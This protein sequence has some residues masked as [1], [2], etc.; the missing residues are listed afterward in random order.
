MYLD[1]IK[2]A[3]VRAEQQ[4]HHT[5]PD[6]SRFDAYPHK[7]LAANEFSD[8]AYIVHS[9]YTRSGQQPFHPQALYHIANDLRTIYLPHFPTTAGQG[10]AINLHDF[11][12]GHKRALGIY[13]HHL[14]DQQTYGTR[15]RPYRA[16]FEIQIH[17]DD[18]LPF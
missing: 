14:L 18:H 7:Y 15:A 1:K 10:T 2:S 4:N 6:L 12:Q 3:P 11:R 13:P 9:R 16:V 5:V 8:V 17:L